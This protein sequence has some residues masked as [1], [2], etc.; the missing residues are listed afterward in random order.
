MYITRAVRGYLPGTFSAK[1]PA[2]MR[3]ETSKRISSLASMKLQNRIEILH[4]VRNEGP[5][6]RVDLQARTRLSWGTISAS[7]RELL[8]SGIFT[9]IGAVTTD[10]GRRPVE[11]D[12]NQADNFVLGLQLGSAVV[13]AALMD[14]KG[15]VVAELDVP[16]NAAGTSAE[17][18][19]CLKETANRLLRQQ[20]VKRGSLMGIGVAVPGAVDFSTGISLYA[21]QHPNWKNVALKDKFERAFGVPC[22]VDHSFNCFALSEQ[23]FGL[24]KGLQNYVCVLIGTGVAAGIV[25]GGQIYRGANGLAGEFGHTCIEENGLPCACGNH[26]CIEA[27]ISGPALAAAAA[28]QRG[29][30][31]AAA[32][33]P[34][35]G[36]DRSGI[37][38]EKLFLAA[39]KGDPVALRGFARMGTVLGLGISNLIN[40]FNPQTV[41][42]GG[43]VCQASEFFLPSCMEAVRQR[44]WHASPKDVKVSQLLRGAVRGAGALVLQQLFATGH[45]VDR[46]VS[47]GRKQ[48]PDISTPE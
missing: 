36:G 39:Q 3:Q 23:L 19:R 29:S 1:L 26:G 12:L 10:M 41:I 24:G 2:E 4:C 32:R 34:A 31:R 17:I 18:L 42:L 7:T 45:I 16:V 21:P 14:I 38:A 13:R 30:R 48:R 46:A 44:A 8:D 9:E 25:L 37:T 27:Y 11:L 28:R 40:I 22:F 33:P 43:F 15:A 20:G 6:S 47:R 5:I 35:A